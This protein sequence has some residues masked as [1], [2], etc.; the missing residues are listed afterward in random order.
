MK[1]KSNYFPFG[2]SYPVGFTHSEANPDPGIESLRKRMEFLNEAHSLSSLPGHIFAAALA[3]FQ[4]KSNEEPGAFWDKIAMELS[5][6]EIADVAESLMPMVAQE[7]PRLDFPNAIALFDCRFV[8]TKEWE[9]I[10]RYS[11]GGSEASTVLGLSKFQSPRS[12]YYEKKA[13]N[14]KERDAGGQQILDY[15]HA[16]EPYVIGEIASRLGASVYPEYRMFAHMDY[17]FLTCNP[18][19]ILMFPDGSLALFEAKT[20]M[21][22]KRTD[23]KDG[24]PDYYA[25]QPRHYMEVLN[26]PRLTKGFIGVCFGGLPKDM[27][28][29]RYVRDV[30]EGVDQ[31]QKL[32]DYWNNYIVPGV[33]PPLSGKA[34]LDHTAVYDYE[35]G[36]TAVDTAPCVL[37]DD[38]IPRFQRYFELAEEKKRLNKEIREAKIQEDTHMKV[39][40]D[41]VQE[42]YTVCQ[43][44]GS[45]AYRIKAVTS[46]RE[47]VSLQS[48]PDINAADAMQEIADTLRDTG[49]D[50]GNPK[51]NRYSK[52]KT[53]TK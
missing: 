6:Q 43:I 49:S 5:L 22:L 2:F 21:W 10:R 40:R 27:L 19:G 42:G 31:T 30:A 35:P 46:K 47:T 13:P 24:I 51:I 50:W 33:L 52:L 4:S 53:A 11:I 41:T 17:P 25:P 36:R 39:I 1:T 20:A 38:L 12:L 14:G 7:P 3:L 15:G 9:H 45:V 32:V 28:C 26:D 37:S 23:W 18:D 48:I 44:P 29:H 8:S 34:K 16:V